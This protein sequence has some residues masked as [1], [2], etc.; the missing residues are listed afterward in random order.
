MKK[1]KKMKPESRL[2]YLHKNNDV[3]S[4]SAVSTKLISFVSY[5]ECYCFAV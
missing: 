2:P 4:F 3:F 5:S 1:I